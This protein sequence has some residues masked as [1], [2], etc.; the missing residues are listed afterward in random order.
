MSSTS[1]SSSVLMA[2]MLLGVRPGLAPAEDAVVR[3][4]A[5]SS[6]GW[7]NRKPWLRLFTS[8]RV[9]DKKGMQL[10]EMRQTAINSMTE[11]DQSPQRLGGLSATVLDGERGRPR[12]PQTLFGCVSYPD[13]TRPQLPGFRRVRVEAAD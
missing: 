3:R 12:V 9:Q 7:E 1:S 11:Q 4:A 6:L 5:E 10:V 8:L 2:A 13:S